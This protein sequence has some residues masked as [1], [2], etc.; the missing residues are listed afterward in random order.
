MAAWLRRGGIPNRSTDRSLVGRRAAICFIVQPL[1][2]L[3]GIVRPEIG[4]DLFSKASGSCK[5]TTTDGNLCVGT[6]P[7][8]SNDVDDLPDV[9]RITGA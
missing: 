9:W 8:R 3:I 2:H 6:T 5:D 1:K 7:D 4:T